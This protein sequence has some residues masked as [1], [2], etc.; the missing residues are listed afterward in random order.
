MVIS[1]LL[2]SSTTALW[3]SSSFLN[4]RH[5]LRRYTVVMTHQVLSYDVHVLALLSTF[6]YLPCLVFPT[7]CVVVYFYFWG[8]FDSYWLFPNLKINCSIRTQSLHFNIANSLIRFIIQA[9]CRI[10]MSLGKPFCEIVFHI[11]QHFYLL[12]VSLDFNQLHFSCWY[13]ST[14]SGVWI[15]FSWYISTLSRVWIL[16]PDLPIGCSPKSCQ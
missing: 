13:I 4:L 3:F 2:S 16:V 14:L 1:F 8:A 9:F 7:T 11:R 15:H 5:C 6:T 10:F 12:T